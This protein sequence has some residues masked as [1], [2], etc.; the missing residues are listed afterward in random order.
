MLGGQPDRVQLLMKNNEYGLTLIE[1]LMASIVG[2]VLLFG[3]VAIDSPRT[4]MYEMLR[5]E[6]SSQHGDAALAMGHIGRNAERADRINII[7]A[8]NFQVRIP[9]SPTGLDSP[10]TYR[11]F[12]YKYNAA[13]RALDYFENIPPCTV[14][15]RIAT[16]L[17]A[18]DFNF[19]D[20]AAAPPGGEPFGDARDNNQFL[21]S[22]TWSNGL[23]A[24]NTLTHTFEGQTAL[25][26]G[27]YSDVSATAVGP[28]ADSGGGLAPAGVSS[29]PAGC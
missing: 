17:S 16:Q 15:T 3:M 14:R 26:S 23:P 8:T 2:G 22:L 1:V 6:M 21:Y 24:P 20:A 18:V 5:Q 11:W 19:R 28:A 4:R 10:G 27:T 12:Q 25:R 13:E 29:P 7:N 9:Q